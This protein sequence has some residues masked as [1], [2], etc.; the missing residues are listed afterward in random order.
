M[1]HTRRTVTIGDVESTIDKDIVLYRGDREVEVEFVLLG[2]KFEFTNAG[3]VI[4]STNASHGQL[5]IDTPQ[6]V[7]LFSEVTPCNEGSVIFVITAEMI[8]ELEEVGLYSFQIRLF[9]EEQ[10]SRISIPPV[11]D[12]IEIRSPL[13]AEDENNLS[14]TAV[15]DK[16]IVQNRNEEIGPTFNDAGDYNKT[17]W[18]KGDVISSG[19]L[20]KL[21]DAI[22]TID[23]NMDEITGYVDTFRESIDTADQ[24]LQADINRVSDR[25]EEVNRN[26]S[27][28]VADVNRNWN[29]V[30]AEMDEFEEE[31]HTYLINQAHHIIVNSQDELKDALIMAGEKGMDVYLQA[32]NYKIDSS[33]IITVNK[34]F[35]IYGSNSTLSILDSEKKHSNGLQFNSDN[36]VAIRIFDIIIDGSSI[37]QD[38]FGKHYND[39]DFKMCVAMLFNGLDVV[40]LNNVDIQNVWGY[41]VTFHGFSNVLVKNCRFIE[42]GG[43]NSMNDD[44]DSFGDAIYIGRREGETNVDIINVTAIGKKSST[45][46]SCGTSNSRVGVTVENLSKNIDVKTTV[47]IRN[48]KFMNYNRCLH[49][50]AN[51]GNVLFNISDTYMA[52]DVI[53]LSAFVDGGTDVNCDNVVFVRDD[54]L[55]G[56]A[57]NVF[58]T[59]EKVFVKNSFINLNARAPEELL[60]GVRDAVFI[61]TTIDG[62]GEYFIANSTAVF[63][64]CTLY[65]VK[66][67]DYVNWGS[68]INFHDCKIVSRDKITTVNS[69]GSRFFN[70]SL[71]N[72]IDSSTNYY[73]CYCDYD[74][75]LD[76][77]AL[78]LNSSNFDTVKIDGKDCLGERTTC[79]YFPRKNT[80]YRTFKDPIDIT[81]L[82]PLNL[83]GHYVILIKGSDGNDIYRLSK[84]NIGNGFAKGYYYIIATRKPSNNTWIFS[85][86]KSFGNSIYFGYTLS[87]NILSANHPVNEIL[88]IP[89]VYTSYLPEFS[90]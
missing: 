85:D 84:G 49:S 35:N 83:Y 43:K 8:D 30:R 50:E 13:A 77:S 31:I 57:K 67:R 44:Y 59:C 62:I 58:Y 78:Q 16:A 88:I 7:K 80:M 25:V 34:S 60:A 26:L 27:A 37:P 11:N 71:K 45:K 9:D 51:A 42:V 5:V 2:N 19:R 73:D 6:G 24:T 1:I 20:N 64:D 70:C 47:N 12:G 74:S 61:Y 82:L 76:L 33:F 4:K 23:N 86:L 10:F 21:E 90:E 55:F 39:S 41:G 38:Q 28:D 29:E 68:S 66:V 22:Y 32:G 15:V 48:S 53:V 72:I 65:Y 56:G 40:E 63:R 81:T 75:T 46:L 36:K 54:G 17:Q 18:V 87:D 79:V 3:N 89:K 14:D 52:G 69:G